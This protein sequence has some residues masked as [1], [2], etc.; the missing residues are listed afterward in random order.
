VTE[1]RGTIHD[2]LTLVAVIL[3]TCCVAVLGWQFWSWLSTGTWQ[4]ISALY[5]VAYFNSI[6]LLGGG[7]YSYGM[8]GFLASIP[9]ALGFALL[10]TA[11]N[12]FANI[13]DG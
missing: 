7:T 6:G 10:G 2:I 4:S 12:L 9:L 8:S 3:W 13:I 11:I 1:I 5:G